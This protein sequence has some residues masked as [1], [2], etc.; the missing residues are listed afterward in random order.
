MENAKKIATIVLAV[1]ICL[2]LLF[3]FAASLFVSEYDETQDRFKINNKE[4]IISTVG[5]VALLVAAFFL[6]R[7]KSYFRLPCDW[8][9]RAYSIGMIAYF[10]FKVIPSNNMKNLIESVFN[11]LPTAV[12]VFNFLIVPVLLLVLTIIRRKKRGTEA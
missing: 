10:L 3:A 8:I 2:L 7:S 12:I 1:L 4:L 5:P 11:D 9:F 6:R